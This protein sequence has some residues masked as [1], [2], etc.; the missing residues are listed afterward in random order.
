MSW[1]LVPLARCAPQP[2]K[3]GGG[4][5][6]ELLAWPD[7]G[8]WRVRMSVAE[9]ARAGPFSVFEGVRRWFAVLEGGGVALGVDGTRH[10]LTAKDDPFAFDGA[11]A[12]ECALLAGPTLDFNL[13]TRDAP[14][15][16]ARVRGFFAASASAGTLVAAYAASG[17]VLRMGPDE[18]QVP[19]AT[20]AW[21]LVQADTGVELEGANVLWME[22]RP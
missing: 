1:H 17:A 8:A 7:A 12:V 5:T 4:I 10:E 6:R 2:W 15:L 19:P 22:V 9:V 11:A 18:R 13:M 14:A 20:L 3:N 16:L 21:Q